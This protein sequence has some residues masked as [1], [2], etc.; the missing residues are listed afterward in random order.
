[1]VVQFQIVNPHLR[2]I[3]VARC[4]SPEIQAM[5]AELEALATAT[6]L[7]WSRIVT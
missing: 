3:Q 1:M 2:E 5:A 6:K 7:A 4:S